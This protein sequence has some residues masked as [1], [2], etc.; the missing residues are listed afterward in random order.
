MIIWVL[1]IKFLTRMSTSIIK[2]IQPLPFRPLKV[3]V[4]L[5]TLMPSERWERS[6]SAVLDLAMFIYK[7]ANSHYK[8]T[9]RT[10]GPPKQRLWQK[11]VK[12]CVN[13][14]INIPPFP[15]AQFKPNVFSG[16][17]AVWPWSSQADAQLMVSFIRA[18][19]VLIAEPEQ[20]STSEWRGD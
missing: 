18:E 3:C 16:A 6:Q 12:M 14:N 4:A 1:V 8:Y 9:I 15:V 5:A 17:Y 20:R 10:D 19:R 13:I 11:R 2:K 7:A